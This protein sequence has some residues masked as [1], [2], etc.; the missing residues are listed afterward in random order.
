VAVAQ[1]DQRATQQGQ[2]TDRYSRAIEQLSSAP[3]RPQRSAWMS[4]APDTPADTRRASRLTVLGRRV[5][6]HD[7]GITMK[8]NN[9]TFTRLTSE[10]RILFDA[11]LKEQISTRQF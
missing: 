7:T 4:A 11:S 10:R 6:A 1:D 3:A 5:T 2:F 9:L 8:L